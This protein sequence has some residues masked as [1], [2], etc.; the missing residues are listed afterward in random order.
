MSRVLLLVTSERY[1]ETDLGYYIN[2]GGNKF[3]LTED[4]RTAYE[5]VRNLIAEEIYGL[6]FLQVPDKTEKTFLINLILAEIRTKYHIAI[7][8]SSPRKATIFLVGGRTPHSAL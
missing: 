7:A 4:Q 5:I 6:L 1:R 8:V 2:N 3:R